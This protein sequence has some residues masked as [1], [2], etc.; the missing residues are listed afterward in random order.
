MGLCLEAARFAGVV[1]ESP[2]LVVVGT[3]GGIRGWV[4][5]VLMEERSGQCGVVRA[6]PGQPRLDC[7]GCSRRRLLLAEASVTPRL[8][9]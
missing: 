6:R 3:K 8:S 9:R 5:G 1:Q 7:G 4:M 2:R